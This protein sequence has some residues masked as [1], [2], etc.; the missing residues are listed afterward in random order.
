L[1]GALGAA[2]SAADVAVTVAANGDRG[3]GSIGGGNDGALP[4]I[5]G[6]Q[7]SAL[8]RGECAELA[9]RWCNCI[10]EVSPSALRAGTKA[11]GLS[12]ATAG[13]TGVKW[14][15]AAVA[16]ETGVNT[17]WFAGAPAGEFGMKTLGLV[18]AAAVAAEGWW[19]EVGLG[20]LNAP[21]KVARG[22]LG[23]PGK[24]G[25]IG[26]GAAAAACRTGEEESSE[27]IAR[28]LSIVEPMCGEPGAKAL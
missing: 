14:P 18:A 7:I 17:R 1:S 26:E 3:R 23:N 24:E 15:S 4:S 10:V 8:P 25:E 2:R 20:K 27:C 5:G 21:G 13:E 11:R 12:G 22:L 19:G 28:R 9:L 16:G 6:A